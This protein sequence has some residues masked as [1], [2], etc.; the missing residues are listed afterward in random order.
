MIAIPVKGGFRALIDD[1]DATAVLRHRWSLLRKSNGRIQAVRA[2]IKVGG[3]WRAILLHRF[4]VDVP[5]G[6][7]ID[8]ANGDPLD[9]RRSNL[10]VC[11]NAQNAM[12]RHRV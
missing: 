1:E 10:R 5:P 3:Q 9:N 2:K 6:K 8:H 4:L 7:Q 12:N 11:S